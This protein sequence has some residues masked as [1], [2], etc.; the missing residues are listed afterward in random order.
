MTVPV[1]RPKFV[2]ELPEPQECT[3]EVREKLRAE[4]RAWSESFAKRAAAV[5]HLTP[6][7]LRAKAR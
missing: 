6:D 3:P 2:S 5:L 7:D 1:E 4:A